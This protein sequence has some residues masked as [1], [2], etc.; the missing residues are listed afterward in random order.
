MDGG[1]RL[2]QP[3]MRSG[4]GVEAAVEQIG[5]SF[6]APH[7]PRAENDLRRGRPDRLAW[8]ASGRRLIGR[9]VSRIVR[10][11]PRPGVGVAAAVLLLAATLGYGAFAGGHVAAI[12]DWLKDA[13]DSAANA[14]GFR[15]AEIGRAHV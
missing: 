15:I 9:S 11:P 10:L 2:D 4:P 13:R 5:M 14:A 12:V 3:L 6:D 7:P 1:G 8:L